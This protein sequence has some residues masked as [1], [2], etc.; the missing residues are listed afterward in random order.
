[1]TEPYRRYPIRLA[2]LDVWRASNQTTLEEAR[3]RFVQFVVLECLS[4]ANVAKDLAFKGGNALR[5]GYGYPRSTF[6]LDFT[7]T[8]PEEESATIRRVVDDAMRAGSA[9]FGIKCKVSSVA[10]N[11]ANLERTRPTFGIKVGYSFPGDRHFVDFLSPERPASRVVPLDI[12]F[13][14]VVCETVTV[15]LGDTL[16]VRIVICTLE[17][18]VAEKLRSILQQAIRNRTRPQ[19]VY[20]VAHA[21]RSGQLDET[22]IRTYLFVKCAAR[23]I[24]PTIDGFS[25]DARVRA[26]LGYADLG[27]EPASAVIPFDTAWAD[28]LGVVHRL[29]A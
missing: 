24:V 21:L 20:D 1:M 7:S 11:P 25:E 10:R 9:D 6:D 16:D 29:L 18:I 4:A 5:F 2:E 14:D 15:S 23:D 13:N 3:Q 17:D 12:S 27:I 26:E 19:D 22:K 28:V 8:V